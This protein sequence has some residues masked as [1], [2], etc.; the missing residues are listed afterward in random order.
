MAA[1]NSS[2]SVRS[3]SAAD[4][5]SRSRPR[6]RSN[7]HEPGHRE[8]PSRVRPDGALRQQRDH[9][10]LP[11]RVHVGAAAEL[12]R[13]R[14]GPHDADRRAVLV[15]EEGDGTHV[16]G[17]VARGLGGLHRRCR[18]ARRRSPGR[19][20]RRAPR[21]SARRDARSRSAGTRARPASPAGGRDRPAPPAAPRAAG[22][23]PCGCAGWPRGA[24]RRW[25]P[26]RPVPPAPHRSPAPG[27][28]P[29]R[30]RRGRCPRPRRCP[31]RSRWCPCPPPARRSRR[32]RACGPGR[33]RRC[34]RRRPRLALA[35]PARRPRLDLEHGDDPRRHLVVLH[36]APDE[37]RR[38]LGLE[39][40]RGRPPRRRPGTTSPRHG[41]ARAARPWRHR[42]RPGPPPPPH[43]APA[44]RSARP[45]S[46]GCRAG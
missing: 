29:A 9:A 43:R 6:A 2:G 45:G 14:S 27:A 20:P 26:A 46:R 25:W 24:R 13:R 35:S 7:R 21:S 12:E 34:G 36:A 23:S 15:A 1:S 38:P 33:S 30:A 32:R 16:L 10:D 28:P 3:S 40:R 31:T 11:Q 18:S 4:C 8:D 37:R 42:S 19:T 17:L 44:P 22:A 41:P 5:T 39:Q